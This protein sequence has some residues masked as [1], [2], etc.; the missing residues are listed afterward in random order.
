MLYVDIPAP[1]DIAALATFRGEGCVSIYLRTTPITQQ[2]QADRIE[3]KNLARRAAEQLEAAG[4]DKRS[5]AAISEELDDLVDDDEFWRFQAHSLAIFVTPQNLRTFRLPNALQPFVIVSDRYHVKPLLRSVSFPQSCYVLALAQ[6]SV[7]VV[8]VSPDLPST[9]I[10]IEGMP[11]D[12]GRAVQGAG[13]AGDWPRS[14][15]PRLRASAGAGGAGGYWPSGRMQGAEGQKVLLR[16]FARQVDKALRPVVTGSGVPLVLAAAE[17]LASTYRSVNSYPHLAAAAIEG[18][19]EAMTEA[20]L[21]DR[22]RTVLDGIYR[23]ELTAWRTLFEARAN[24][25]RATTDVAQAARAAT[26][27]AVDSMLMDIDETLSGR[28]A[29]DGAVV[30]AEQP[31]ATNSDLVDEIATRVITTGGRVI[32]VRKAEIPRAAALAAMLRY[33]V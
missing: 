27:G 22:A 3:L 10:D 16:Q 26:A 18:N 15:R 2:A 29:D 1:S 31:T 12:A 11:E 13:E 5:C 23:D 33:P 25:G 9:A 21:G 8:E 4:T 30:F 32:G 24:Q 7:R 20:Q 28:I 19:P 17:P 14:P 6:K